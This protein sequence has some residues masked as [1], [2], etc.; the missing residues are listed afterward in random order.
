MSEIEITEDNRLL[1]LT[2]KLCPY[3][4]S[5]TNFTDSK[6]IY[7]GVSYGMVYVCWPCNAYVGVHI[8]TKRALGRLANSEL[9]IWK[10]EAHAW[11]DPL[12]KKKVSKGVS[13]YEARNAAYTW[14]SENLGIIKEFTH[15]GM[16]DVSQ[17]KQVVELCKK[18]Y[19]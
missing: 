11:F 15:I 16:F 18:H 12:W 5:K 2:G 9:R 7:Q 4:G 13:K 6:K 1:I 14:L 19:K 8:G 3:C 17:C 10:K